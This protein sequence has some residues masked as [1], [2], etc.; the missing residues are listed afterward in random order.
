ML[1][2]FFK[3][4]LQEEYQNNWELREIV[5]KGELASWLITQ[6]ESL[7]FSIEDD[8]ND[9][10]Q[11]SINPLENIVRLIDNDLILSLMDI[12]EAPEYKS[13][14]EAQWFSMLEKAG[15]KEYYRF[16]RTPRYNNI[17]KIYAPLYSNHVHPLARLLYNDGSLSVL[18]T[19]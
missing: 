12:L 6:I 1:N 14:T 9:S 11:A 10:Y 19:K 18:A 4:L 15:F 8:H 2:R 16:G 7:K 13:Y 3:E 5:A 17:R